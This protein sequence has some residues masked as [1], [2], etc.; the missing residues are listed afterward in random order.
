MLNDRKSTKKN[1][2]SLNYLYLSFDKICNW[3]FVDSL[4]TNFRRLTDLSTPEL[5]ILVCTE[6]VQTSKYNAFICI[7]CQCHWI[8]YSLS[9]HVTI[10]T[11][12]LI[13]AKFVFSKTS[14]AQT[15]LLFQ[16]TSHKLRERERVKEKRKNLY[17]LRF[18]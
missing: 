7:Q 1:K 12:Q 3:H 8:L 15:S 2:I 10:S 6:Q 5:H 14:I 17:W 11:V 9:S 18:G 16:Y 13:S 4:W